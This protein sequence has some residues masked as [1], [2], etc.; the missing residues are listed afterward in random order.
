[1][2]KSENNIMH[3]LCLM[4]FTVFVIHSHPP[5]DEV[6]LSPD[7]EIPA[8]I[9]R[10][11]FVLFISSFLFSSFP[12]QDAGI[13][14]VFHSSST[15]DS[16]GLVPETKAELTPLGIFYNNRVHSN[17]K[18]SSVL[19]IFKPYFFIHQFTFKSV[20]LYTVFITGERR[21]AHNSLLNY[22]VHAKN[23]THTQAH[24]HTH[25]HTAHTH[26]QAHAL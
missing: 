9:P 25:T 18:V 17:F 20:F 6:C 23:Y 26:T 14:F 10:M 21:V 19:H 15:G 11:W 3:T 12:F 1:M 8:V 5:V 13:W 4:R 16:H 22:S 24:T 7:N 2:K